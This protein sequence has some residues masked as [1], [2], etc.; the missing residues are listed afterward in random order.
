MLQV[1]G[2]NLSKHV[3]RIG[4]VLKFKAQVKLSSKGNRT[5]QHYCV[6]FSILCPV[7]Q[8]L[9]MPNR[10]YTLQYFNYKI[11]LVPVLH[12]TSENGPLILFGFE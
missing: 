8:F 3:T 12:N 1:T 10:Q 2:S 9:G 11:I 4:D 7:F 5:L 6:R